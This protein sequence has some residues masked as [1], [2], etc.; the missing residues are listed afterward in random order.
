MRSIGTTFQ[1]KDVVGHSSL[2][3]LSRTLQSKLSPTKDV[4]DVAINLTGLRGVYILLVCTFHYVLPQS[5]WWMSFVRHFGIVSMLYIVSGFGLG[6]AALHGAGHHS[7]NATARFFGALLPSYFLGVAFYL[8]RRKLNAIEML[9]LFTGMQNWVPYFVMGKLAGAEGGMELWWVTAYLTSTIIMKIGKPPLGWLV[10]RSQTTVALAA[11]GGATV[12]L[13]IPQLYVY[14][15]VSLSHLQDYPLSGM[16]YVSVGI[17]L[18]PWLHARKQHLQGWHPDLWAVMLVCCS[19]TSFLTYDSVQANLGFILARVVQLFVM[20]NFVTAISC[21]NGLI[22]GPLAHAW[23]QWLGNSSWDIYVLHLPAATLI[24][25][26]L[27]ITLEDFY[28]FSAIRFAVLV[29]MLACVWLLRR[30]YEV[31]RELRFCGVELIGSNSW[32]RCPVDDERARWSF[33]IMTGG[34]SR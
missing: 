24:R 33:C 11:A 31:L 17:L 14:P 25:W 20:I 9:A 32:K 21:T 4:P 2:Y 7:W 27:S 28:A 19:V 13:W 12:L 22:T 26:L 30:V 10:T 15:T 18:A 3:E 5:G 23:V 34:K 29:L 6:Q 1:L 16:G 8:L